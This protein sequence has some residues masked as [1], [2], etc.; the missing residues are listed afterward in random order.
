MG[1]P[2]GVGAAGCGRN[3]AGLGRMEP[4]D[5]TKITSGGEGRAG[6]GLVPVKTT[7]SSASTD[8]DCCVERRGRDA[9]GGSELGAI[10]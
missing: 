8:S 10:H 5:E 9:D 1:S 3:A 2:A 7:S 4:E 6:A